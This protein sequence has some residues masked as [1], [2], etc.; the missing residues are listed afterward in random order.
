MP[1]PGEIKKNLRLPVIAAPMFLVSGPDMV[2]AACKAGIV[3]SFPTP[4]ARTIDDLESWMKQ[5]TGE[6][7]RAK[8]EDPDRIIG[9]W[10]ANVVVHSSN[11][12][13]KQDMELV[14]RYKPPLVITALGSPAAVVGAV[15]DYGGKVLADVN[16]VAFARKAAAAGVD[17]LVLVASGAG[18]HTGQMSAFAFVSAVRDF[19]DGIIVL[20]GSICDGAAVRAA[21]VLGADLAYM[22]TRFIAVEESLAQDGYRQMLVDSTFE[23]ILCTNAFTGAYANMLKPSIRHAGLD[24]DNLRARD[25]IDFTDPQS[26]S[27]AWKN[28]WS[29]G[30]GVDSVTKVEPLPRLVDQLAREYE[31][32]SRKPAFAAREP[33]KGPRQ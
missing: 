33:A 5:I 21:E 8:A 9:P 19:F 26:D 17:G 3:G 10:A 31:L 32:A 28:I 23:D 16:S 15:H 20:A 14:I 22:G 2:I 1:L 12:R 24:P 11:T 6:L 30:H 27:K 7:A 4:N 29:A 25:I 18:G 13:L